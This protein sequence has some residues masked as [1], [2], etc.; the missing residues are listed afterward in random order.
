MS[1][2][3]SC[4]QAVLKVL[5]CKQQQLDQRGPNATACTPLEVSQ[6]CHTDA[7]AASGA[8]SAN[9][10]NTTAHINGL[11]AYRAA[12]WDFLNQNCGTELH[13]DQSAL[14]AYSRAL[15]PGTSH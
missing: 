4:A 1:V 15:L 12:N 5:E 8:C 10:D 2:D 7:N 9:G 13:V 6:L 11:L 3:A 14:S